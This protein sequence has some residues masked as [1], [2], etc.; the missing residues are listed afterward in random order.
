MFRET[1]LKKKRVRDRGFILTSSDSSRFTQ[2]LYFCDII[3]EQMLCAQI[4]AA[5]EQEEQARKQRL[6]YKV[7][8]LISAMS[9]ES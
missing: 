3:R 4:T 5:L 7:E 8:Q 9:F 6:S 1:P 2:A